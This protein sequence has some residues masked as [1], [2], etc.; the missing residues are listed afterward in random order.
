MRTALGVQARGH[1]G[2]KIV[3]DAPVR[4][5]T[6]ADGGVDSEMLLA[7]EALFLK[8]EVIA[9]GTAA[10]QH[11]HSTASIIVI[12][13]GRVRVNYGSVFQYADYAEAGEFIFIPALMPHQ[14][15]NEEPESNLVCLVIRNAPWDEVLPYEP[16]RKMPTF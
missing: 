5:D 15:V 1:D 9:P 2:L 3:K 6:I 12:L 14:P 8:R 7:G 4:P 16:P 13:E 11:Y 10:N